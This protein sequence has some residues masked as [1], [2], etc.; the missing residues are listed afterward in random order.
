MPQTAAERIRTYLK[1]EGLT[2]ER[3]GASCEPPITGQSVRNAMRGDPCGRKVALA[4]ARRVPRV[5]VEELLA[6]EAA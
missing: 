1:R 6:P 4:L 2:P 5:A 3:L